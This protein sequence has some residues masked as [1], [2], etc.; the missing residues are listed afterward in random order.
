[1]FS[2]LLS[3][4]NLQ[5]LII[6][7]SFNQYFP[8]RKESAIM[9]AVIKFD[10]FLMTIYP[11]SRF[12][13]VTLG[14][15]LS[16]SL[17]TGCS[18]I[19]AQAESGSRVTTYSQEETGEFTDQGRS[20]SYYI[21]TPKSYNPD[22]PMPLVL[23]FH[24]DDGS[25]RAI[26]AVTRFNDLAEQ[27][28]FIAVYPNASQDNPKH[29]WS[30][31]SGARGKVDDVAFVAALLDRLKQVRNIDTHKIYATGF[32]R[33]GILVQDLA[34]EL[35]DRI[36]AFASVA[37]SLPIGVKAN[38]H[39]QTPVSVLMINGTNDLSI[40]YDGHSKGHKRQEKGLSPIP[41]LI[42]FWR[43]LDACPST[44]QVQPLPDPNPRD[45]FSVKISRYSSCRNNS[46][47]MLAAVINGGHFWPGGA[48]QDASLKQF[49]DNLGFNATQT[50]WDFLQRHSIP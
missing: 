8:N 26:A 27:Q 3:R 48:T 14:C 39:P 32:S 19:Q 11:H 16:M 33:G 9:R 23:V 28:G 42:N 17:M 7:N 1:M 38:C 15:I 40:R 36:A 5:N 18:Q 47:V 31:K 35:P 50:V 41:D 6:S 45:R 4:S 46:E 24:G 10:S 2:L 25:G 44:T 43:S 22:R 34:C 49:N 30:L 20:R 37:G 13:K 29:K 12:L 21:Y